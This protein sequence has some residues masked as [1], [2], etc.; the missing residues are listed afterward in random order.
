MMSSKIII[1]FVVLA[2]GLTFH[3]EEAHGE[4]ILVSPIYGEGSHF[5]AASAIGESLV[6]RGHEV[7]FLISNAYAHRAKDP[8]YAKFSFEIFNHSLPV[9][10][11]RE[12]MNTIGHVAFEG[13]S[14]QFN[15]MLKL[16]M[17]M[18]GENCK[19]IITDRALMRRLEA[20]DAMIMDISWPCGVYIR[21][22]LQKGRETPKDL[23]M[24]AN[25]PTTLWSGFVMAAGSPFNYAYMPETMT[26][27]TN[28]MNFFQRLSNLVQSTLIKASIAS[29]MLSSFQK[30]EKE[31]G[32]QNTVDPFY[33][34]TDFDLYL[35]NIHF[36]SDFP[37]PMVPN[38]IAVG[39]L[40][41]KQAAH[42]EKVSKNT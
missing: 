34:F 1:V 42:L 37:V 25:S 20:M 11:V 6:K 28:R 31:V 4:N 3:I 7:T 13:A 16:M 21:A 18:T 38:L 24:I 36:S 2:T 23:K 14:D 8:K 32:L 22:A 9:E 19:I 30:M 39:G 35:S 33:G 10:T 17:E 12:M 5:L 27:F 41:T 15:T 40:T 29:T 26:G